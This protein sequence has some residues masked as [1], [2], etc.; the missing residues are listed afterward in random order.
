MIQKN[1]FVNILC[2]QM[3]MSASQSLIVSVH[4]ILMYRYFTCSIFLCSVYFYRNHS[5]SLVIKKL[6]SLNFPHLYVYI[7]MLHNANRLAFSQPCIFSRLKR[8]A[9]ALYWIA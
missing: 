7:I 6:Y 9:H 3:V 5:D 1:I 2:M 4:S 8:N